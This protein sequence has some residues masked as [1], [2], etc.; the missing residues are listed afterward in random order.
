ML[1]PWS[2]ISGEPSSRE[3]SHEDVF[4]Q[5]YEWLLNW[6][7][8]LTRNDPGL[9]EDLVHDAFIQFT[10]SR[11][12]LAAI[13]NLEGYLYGMLRN[14][15]LS[16]LR[17]GARM[18]GR[19][20]SIVDYDSAELVLRSADP[21]AQ[22][23]AREELRSICGYAC[24]RKEKSKA[25]SVLIFRFFH[26]YYPGEIARV[27]RSTRRAVD[28][29]LRI[30]RREVKLNLEGPKRL[31]VLR[32]QPPSSAEPKDISGDP[33]DFIARLRSV[34]FR[35]R[36]GRCLSEEE[37]REIYGSNDEKTAVPCAVVAHIVSCPDCL[38]QVNRT[39]NL[40]PSC[41]RH[42]IDTMGPEERVQTASEKTR[43]SRNIL[44]AVGRRRLTEIYE[45][46]PRELFVSVNGIV[47]GSQSIGAEV[48]EQHLN[49][50]LAERIAFAEVFSEQG[51]RLIYLDLNPPPEGEVEQSVRVQL[52]EGRSLEVSARF[53]DPRPG[54]TAT[55]CDPSLAPVQV[56]RSPQQLESLPQK[57]EPVRKEIQ[58]RPPLFV[59]RARLSIASLAWW[60]RPA[61]IA[62]FLAGILALGLWL[63]P[64]KTPLVSAAELL[65]RSIASE[66]AA[67]AG[68]NLFVHSET[69]LEARRQSDGALLLRNRIDTWVDPEKGLR[70]RRVYDDRQRLIAAEWIMQN[71]SRLVYREG[72]KGVQP[73]QARRRDNPLADDSI[74][75]LDLTAK[76]FSS[77]VGQ[78]ELADVAEQ[79]G[80]YVVSYQRNDSRAVANLAGATLRIRKKD[81]HPIEQVLLVSSDT[82]G[83]IQYRFTEQSLERVA[84]ARAPADAFQVDAPLLSRAEKIVPTPDLVE[85]ASPAPAASPAALIRSEVDAL[86][87]MHRAGACLRE[88]PQFVRSDGVLAIQAIVEGESRKAELEQALGSVAGSPSVSVE[89][90]TVAQAAE[91]QARV[92]A[93]TGFVR[94]IEIATTRI[95]VYDEL[96][97]RFSEQPAE[98]GSTPG[99]EA[100]TD[101]KIRQFSNRILRAAGDALMHA[102]VLRRYAKWISAQDFENLDSDARDKWRAIIREHLAALEN[103]SSTIREGLQPVFFAGHGNESTPE[104]A[105]E[106]SGFWGDVER[107]F[108]LA[109]ANERAIR[110]AFSISAAG[111]PSQDGRG[112][113]LTVRTR[114]FRESLLR[115]ERLASRMRGRE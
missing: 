86:Y 46:S 83:I 95:P 61:P 45:H 6:A 4:L 50:D 114:E 17:R 62:I 109:S 48:N 14:M 13:H 2:P 53:S 24:V 41:Q 73:S 82:E 99:G 102:W 85:E 51:L 104:L 87:R 71:G 47:I 74:W 106:S 92:P 112:G 33:D 91:R 5:R 8:H 52:S 103:N 110:G 3:L 26:G 22:I 42:P 65:R 107:L 58:I 38:E 64:S 57:L 97:R 31:I 36:R 75:Q 40:P 101:A 70:A 78:G 32:E 54:I 56:R 35:S 59:Q 105:V 84:P 68:S 1:R 76:E 77:L 63:I 115:T 20:I 28:D 23:Q 108:E 11:P 111:S 90:M 44:A 19:T 79:N 10:L 88:Q 60:L 80:A 81:F 16:K 29:W 15:H 21:R 18:Q 30:A 34:I 72:E 66:E 27:L 100:A 98:P 9:A 94:R 7:L 67:F 93:R 12:D 55:Y 49:I 89:I 37:I 96:K 113:D 69:S 39:L 43:S 25:G